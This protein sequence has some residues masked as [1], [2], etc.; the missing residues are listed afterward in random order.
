MAVSKIDFNCPSCGKKNR[1]KI[2]NIYSKEDITEIL[3]RNI[4]KI[5]C[6]KCKNITT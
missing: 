6:S 2:K 5:E 3:N 4:F 1:V